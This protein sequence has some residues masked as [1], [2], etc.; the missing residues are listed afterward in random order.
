[1]AYIAIALIL[2]LSSLGAWELWKEFKPLW[3]KDGSKE[4]SSKDDPQTEEGSPQVK[5]AVSKTAK[6]ATDC[7]YC[8]IAFKDVA[9]WQCPECSAHAHDSCMSEMGNGICPTLGCNAQFKP[10][11]SL[12]PEQTAYLEQQMENLHENLARMSS[13]MER[14]LEN[15]LGNI[16][17]QLKQ[18]F[19][20]A[21]RGIFEDPIPRP[22]RKR[23][24][25]KQ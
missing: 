2:L 10:E 9:E 19:N 12:S 20:D 16:G 11:P 5:V 1:M 7:V 25:R 15:T 18:Q 8:H 6:A 3:S 14:T 17:P 4:E 13:Q 22:R 23:R 21:F 24:K